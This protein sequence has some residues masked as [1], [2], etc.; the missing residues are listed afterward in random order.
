[1]QSR[2]QDR[3][4]RSVVG[5]KAWW[6]RVTGFLL[7]FVLPWSL[8]TQLLG[9]LIVG[10][11]W[12]ED[13]I[14]WV[15]SALAFVTVSAVSAALSKHGKAPAQRLVG[16]R[17][18]DASG[19]PASRPRMFA[20]NLAHL[21]DFVSLGLGFLWPLWSTRGQTF[22]DKLA[23]TTVRRDVLAGERS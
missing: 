13:S 23:G 18:L 21:A 12:P 4:S 15:L 16:V 10:R 5:S 14:G 22:A 8:L 1:M 2:S 7:G 20:R 11:S 6:R 17:V 19:G 3:D 9:S